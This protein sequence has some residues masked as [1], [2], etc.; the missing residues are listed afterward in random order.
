MK[1]N[2]NEAKMIFWMGQHIYDNGQL[3]HEMLDFIQKLAANMCT[4]DVSKWDY[5]YNADLEK[6]KDK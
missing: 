2:E 3:T 5:I 1:I 6:I 4:I